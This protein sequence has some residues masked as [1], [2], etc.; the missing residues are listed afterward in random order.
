MSHK[1]SEGLKDS[2]LRDQT[3]RVDMIG[4]QCN[5]TTMTDINSEALEA[6]FRKNGAINESTVL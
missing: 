5:F 6:L 4:R 1:R 2:T 3:G